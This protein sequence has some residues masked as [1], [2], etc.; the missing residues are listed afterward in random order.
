[1]RNGKQAN[2]WVEIDQATIDLEPTNYLKCSIIDK[3]QTICEWQ[4]STQY[5]QVFEEHP[6][7]Y[8]MITT[9]QHRLQNIRVIAEKVL[10]EKIE[11][12]DN[13]SED[14]KRKKLVLMKKAVKKILFT[15]LEEVMTTQNI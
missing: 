4:E 15:P 8:L 12:G 5:K 9:G 1:M 7:R 14:E 10:E 6:L 13:L 11:I 2:F 3:F